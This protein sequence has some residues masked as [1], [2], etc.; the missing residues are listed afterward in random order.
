MSMKATC[1]ALALVLFLAPAASF[2]TKIP[3]PIEGATLN[4]SFQL[5]TQVLFNQNG[6][7]D[8]Q[9]PSMDIFVRRSRLLV[10]GDINQNF[11][12]LIQIDNPNFGKY[13]NYTGRA[14]VQDAWIGWAPTGI[15][16]NNVVYIDAGIL[17]VPISHHLLESTTNFITADVHTDSF[18][19]PGN[20]FPNLRETGVQV[21]GWALDKHIG[22]RGGIYEGGYAP[23]V[24]TPRVTPK[25]Y[26][27]FAGFINFD[28]I[29]SEEGGWLYGAYKW[30]KDPILSIGGS[31][32]YQSQAITNYTGT[33]LTDQRLH[34][35][36]VYLNYP[37]G[38][39]EL[40]VEVT[41]YRNA[42]SGSSS[43]S[44]NTGYGFD[45]DVGYRFGPFAPY[46]SYS[47]FQA[48]DCD[49]GLPAADLAVCA[50]IVETANSRNIKAG[51]NFFFNK[52]LNH[53]NIEF[54]ANHGLSAY[55][56]ANVAATAGYVPL[57]LDP[58]TPGGLRRAFNAN[59]RNP[60]FWSVLLHWN[61]LF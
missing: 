39:S 34:S 24:L 15:T 56:P 54:Q 18:R 3:I 26:P 2:A 20:N 10:N 49:S 32:I 47:Y 41:G 5:Q 61:V 35:L 8:G 33:S 36:D 13:G 21:R 45:A 51:L 6:T 27:Q 53:L 31:T 57:A 12:Y 7:P 28:I 60:A 25:R 48:D 17:L 23:S 30:G 16:G 50:P 55:G 40:V 42:N 4:V 9:N 11:T 44:A 37:M 22:W 19:F 14:I 52:N 1:R 29:G 59:L 58:V 43:G 46:V 38:D